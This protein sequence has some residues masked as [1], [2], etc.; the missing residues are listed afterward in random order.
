M[1][2]SISIMLLLVF[3]V[4]NPISAL[5]ATNTTHS[6]D[7]TRSQIEQIPDEIRF[8]KYIDDLCFSVTHYHVSLVSI[9]ESIKYA[10][11]SINKNSAL[12]KYEYLLEFVESVRENSLGRSEKF[13]SI[14]EITSKKLIK[15]NRINDLFRLNKEFANY[16]SR[17]ESIEELLKHYLENEKYAK[18]LTGNEGVILAVENANTLGLLYKEQKQFILAEKFYKKALDKASSINDSL[19]IG[20]VSGNLGYIYYH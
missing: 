3:A 8:D 12:K 15:E 6:D 14:H 4:L 7:V 11:A 10:H 1:K 17:F 13:I 9:D 18:K 5:T 16:L 2:F 19:W 20:V